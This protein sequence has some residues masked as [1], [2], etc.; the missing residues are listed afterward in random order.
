MG[1]TDFRISAGPPPQE[2]NPGIPPFPPECPLKTELSASDEDPLSGKESTEFLVFSGF[3]VLCMKKTSFPTKFHQLHA[4]Q[5]WLWPSVGPRTYSPL[6][7]RERH[8]MTSEL[9]RPKIGAL[10][11]ATIIL[12][13]TYLLSPLP[14]PVLLCLFSS[15]DARMLGV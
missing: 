2:R 3:S 7:G 12:S 5:C 14:P 11:E 4:L 15:G 9:S 13:R 10:R 6:G 1:I 8:I